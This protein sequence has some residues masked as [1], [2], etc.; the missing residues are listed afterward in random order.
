MPMY[1]YADAASESSS[2][3]QLEIGYQRR[4]GTTT[5]SPYIFMIERYADITVQ[6]VG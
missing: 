6:V 2:Q 5:Q 4:N 1:K 3:F